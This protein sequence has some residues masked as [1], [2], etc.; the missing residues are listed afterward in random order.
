MDSE[1]NEI[2]ED[3]TK[4]SY[5]TFFHAKQDGKTDA[6]AEYA[7]T[8]VGQD[9]AKMAAAEKERVARLEEEKANSPFGR[10]KTWLLTNMKDAGKWIKGSLIATGIT[11]MGLFN[12][13]II[14]IAREFLK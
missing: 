13:R 10:F 6:E 1:D 11:L 7:A 4:P 9:R 2:N 12:D 8:V 5:T 3:D 14:E